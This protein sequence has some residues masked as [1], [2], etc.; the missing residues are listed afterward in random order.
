VD[1]INREVKTLVYD[2]VACWSYADT[3]LAGRAGLMAGDGGLVCRVVAGEAA[4]DGKEGSPA[5]LEAYRYGVEQR[6]FVLGDGWNVQGGMP[7]GLKIRGGQLVL[8]SQQDGFWA[9]R[10]AGLGSGAGLENRRTVLIPAGD[11]TLNV[12]AAVVDLRGA[13]LW[14]PRGM[15]G[16]GYFGAESVVMPPPTVEPAVRVLSAPVVGLPRVEVMGTRTIGPIR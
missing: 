4:S 12:D 9:I 14:V 1:A 15:Y 7:Q 11:Y 5:R 2:G 10:L 6:G 16:V 13:G 8:N 3:G